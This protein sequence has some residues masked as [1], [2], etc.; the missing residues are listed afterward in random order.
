MAEPLEVGEQ[1]R[2]IEGFAAGLETDDTAA[3]GQQLHHFRHQSVAEIEP[4]PRFHFAAY[5]HMEAPLPQRFVQQQFHY[6]TADFAAEEAGFGDLRVVMEDGTAFGDEVE[7][8]PKGGVDDFTALAVDDQQ[9]GAVPGLRRF[10]GDELRGR[11]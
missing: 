8:V 6:A 4:C 11:V 3:D 5:Q 10:G 7:D 1:G 2:E 9:P